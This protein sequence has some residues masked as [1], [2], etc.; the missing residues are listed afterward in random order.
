[1]VVTPYQFS[2]KSVVHKFIRKQAYGSILVFRMHAIRIDHRLHLL[3]HQIKLTAPEGLWQGL[4][5]LI[6]PATQRR[7]RDLLIVDD[8]LV[9]TVL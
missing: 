1:M 7:I 3:W 4:P 8:V 6:Y 5:G 9:Y 2:G